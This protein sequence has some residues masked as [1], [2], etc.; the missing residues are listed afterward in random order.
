MIEIIE[1]EVFSAWL[2]SLRDRQARA[3]ILARLDRIRDGNL[4]DVE[5]VGEGISEARIHY[6]AGYR[7]YFL[8]RGKLV[9][10]MLAGGDKSSQK[11][12][13]KRAR[14]LAKAWR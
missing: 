12:D 14:E 10:I 4:G 3:K 13:I 1:H 2:A 7:L 6:G 9:I 8:Q 5:P 11:R